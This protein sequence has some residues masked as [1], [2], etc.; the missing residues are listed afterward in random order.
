MS[1][2]IKFII[3]NKAKLIFLIILAIAI[4]TRLYKIS[5]IP[6]GVNVDEA[7]MAYDA[8]CLANYG[9]DRYLNHNPVYLINFGG[10][11]SAM[12]AYVAS[13]FIKIL[14][15][16]IFTIRLP[17]FFLG[18][19]AI[20]LSFFIVKDKLGEKFAL[21]FM[22]L[23]TICPWHIMSSRWGLDCNL[24]APM[25]II[26]MYFLLRAKTWKG[27]IVAGIFIGLTLYTYALS[28][29][30]IPIFLVLTLIYMLYTKKISL[31]SVIIMGIPILLL[32]IPLM[33][34][35]LVNNGYINEIKG[36]IT[37]PKLWVYRGNEIKIETIIE[38][39]NFF[40]T[41][42]TNDELVYNALPEFGTVYIFASFLSVFGFFIELNNLIKNIKNKKF[43]INSVML[44]LFM[45]VIMCMLIIEG[46]NINKANA[47][48]IPLIFFACIA[49]KHIYKNYIYAFYIIMI[50]YV[51]SFVYFEDF[52]FNKYSI[53][54]E[55]QPFFESDLIGALNYVD[56]D[57]GFKDKDIYI[58]TSSVQPYIYTLINKRISPYEFNEMIYKNSENGF[59]Y[60][61]YYSLCVEYED[62]VEFIETKNKIPKNK[63]M[64]NYSR[65]DASIEFKD[66]Y[67]KLINHKVKK[68]RYYF[69]NENLRDDVIYIIK[70]NDSL[71][72]QLSNNNFNIEKLKSYTIVYKK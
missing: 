57:L 44:F 35:L 54:Y 63:L 39:L 1:K 49:I 24:L 19:I 30:I 43:E 29:I 16:S 52:Y 18:I 67:S 61:R 7:G 10:G 20:V 60:G 26:S 36:F 2:M 22:A 14:G 34:M 64:H 28:Y 17:A 72:T 41:M 71:V 58:F 55:Y 27:Y 23:I 21:T 3:N 33:L 5:E 46:P 69:Y 51:I 37:I 4:F 53:K 31:K 68:T 66:K 38:N 32:A 8:Y 65:E 15:F 56:N 45:S 40:K 13:F 11:Q 25:S 50:L 70:D 12:Y 42:F 9:T 59:S 62:Y 48:F 6:H 47:C